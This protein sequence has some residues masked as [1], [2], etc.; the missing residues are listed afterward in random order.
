[1][2]QPLVSVVIPIYNVEKYLDRC[3]TSVVNQTYGNLEIILV[4]DGSPDNCSEMC[5]KWAKKDSRIKVIHKQN[6]GLGMARNTGIENSCGKYIFFFDS[7]DYVDVSTV[8]KCVDEILKNNSDAVIYGRYDVYDDGRRE[9]QKVNAAERYFNTASIRNKLLPGMFTYDM[10]FG[11]S[12][13]SKMFNADIIRSRNLRFR[14]ETEIISE[15]AFFI[16]EF[17][18]EINSATVI[19]DMLYYYCKR[20]NS[21]TRSFKK[22][23]QIRNNVFLEKC[24]QFAKKASLP[25]TVQTHIKAR[26]HSYT[27]AAIK[28]IYSSDLPPKKKK[29]EI[30]NIFRDPVL[31]STLSKDVLS[32]ESTFVKLF[33]ITIKKKYFFL[34][35]VLLWLRSLK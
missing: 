24:L 7:D 14:S 13:C 3:I 16:L 27:L 28:Q 15:D 17:F 10:G 23:R 6:A 9:E 18:S 33:F 8:E 32:I 21:L 11:V 29:N 4:D 12:S 5:D 30:Y 26:Y 34:S 31:H 22:D 1:M 19:P 20:D 25:E 35:R 2:N